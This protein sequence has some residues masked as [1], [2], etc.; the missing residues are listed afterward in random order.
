MWDPVL[1]L[2]HDPPCIGEHQ[3]DV[4]CPLEGMKRYAK[5]LKDLHVTHG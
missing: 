1:A 4:F 3:A 2:V 5:L